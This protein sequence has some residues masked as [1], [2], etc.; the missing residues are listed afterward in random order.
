MLHGIPWIF[1]ANVTLFQ[2]YISFT[3]GTE[4]NHEKKIV[5]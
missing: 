1:R 5:V 2:E 3:G 4:L